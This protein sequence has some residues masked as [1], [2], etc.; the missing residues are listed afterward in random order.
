ML[1]RFV[2]NKV[3]YAL[4]SPVYSHKA[5]YL[6]NVHKPFSLVEKCQQFSV[7]SVQIK[8]AG[9]SFQHFS[10]SNTSKNE[11]YQCLNQYSFVRYLSM[12]LLK[13]PTQL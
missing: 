5:Y 4:H 10:N 11:H 8:E 2:T 9:N 13:N 3:T 6:E 7:K 12:L 1:K